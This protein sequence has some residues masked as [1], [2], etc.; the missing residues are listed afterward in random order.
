MLLNKTEGLS[1]LAFLYVLG[2]C[3]CFYFTLYSVWS[4]VMT[5]GKEMLMKELWHDLLQYFTEVLGILK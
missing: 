5:A 3:C 4:L 2:W 1:F